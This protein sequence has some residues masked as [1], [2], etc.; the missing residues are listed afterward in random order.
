M[1][2]HP[3][4]AFYMDARLYK[5]LQLAAHLCMQMNDDFVLVIDGKE[6]AGKSKLARQIGYVLAEEMKVSFNINNIHFDLAQYIK[7]AEEGRT[8]KEKGRILILDESR[9]VLN[10]KRSMS[11]SNVLFTNYLSECRSN[12][13]VHI[14]LLPA[15]HDLDRYITYWRCKLFINVRKFWQ[16]D[17]GSELGF[18]LHRGSYVLYDPHKMQSHLHQALKYGVYTYPDYARQEICEFGDVEVLK[19]I[20][21]YEEKKAQARNEKYNLAEPEEKNKWKDEYS[22]LCNKLISLGIVRNQADLAKII[23]KPRSSMSDIIKR[24]KSEYEAI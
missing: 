16:E 19:D 15:A 9:N 6:G 18:K 22:V 17:E 2:P 12:N 4:G 23:D 3:D 7:F 11:R 10:K 20:E 14:L 5:K 24:T 1:I 21:Q 8:V 13:Q